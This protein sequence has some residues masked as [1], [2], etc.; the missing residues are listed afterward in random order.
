MT[1]QNGRNLRQRRSQIL[2]YKKENDRIE[3][4]IKKSIA[5]TGQYSNH[6][7]KTFLVVITALLCTAGA[8][9]GGTNRKFFGRFWQKSIPPLQLATR[10]P[11]NVILERDL[12]RFFRQYTIATPEN[13]VARNAV[14]KVLR[15]RNQLERRSSRLRPTV[16]AWDGSHIEQ[17]LEQKICGDD[18][19]AAYHS[20]SQDGKDDLLMWCLVASGLTEGYF[21]PFLEMIDSPL[22]LTLKRGIVV[23]R[24]TLG[25]VEDGVGELSTSFYLHPRINDNTAI[26]YLPAKILGILVSSLE[27]ETDLNGGEMIGKLLYELVVTQGNEKEFLILKELCQQNRP[28]RSVAYETRRD[29][30]RCYIVVP[31]KYGGNFDTTNIID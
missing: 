29:G 30:E 28:R 15:N 19:N 5:G 16:K 11:T 20:A 7:I 27:R 3:G 23:Q 18:F 24:Q 13:A 25:G 14:K 12:P 4:V 2:E 6:V 21:K 31:E 26:D 10:Y 9:L 1:D 8:L 22:F 17:L